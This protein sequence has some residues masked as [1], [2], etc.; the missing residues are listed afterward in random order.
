MVKIRAKNYQIYEGKFSHELFPTF[1]HSFVL[2]DSHAEEEGDREERGCQNL[3]WNSIKLEK[4]V[5][6]IN[7]SI[8]RLQASTVEL[9]LT[10]NTHKCIMLWLPNI[11]RLVKFFVSFPA[12]YFINERVVLL[13][14]RF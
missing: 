11:A 10:E 2:Q 5:A 14:T 9:H 1:R 13:W 6:G 4:F 3:K 8:S 7:A 12:A